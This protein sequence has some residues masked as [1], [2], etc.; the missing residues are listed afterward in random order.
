MSAWYPIDTAPKDGTIFDAWLGDAEAGEVSFYCSPDTRRSPDW[1]WSEGKFRPA[2]GLHIATFVVPT[3]WMP[4]P[5]AP[6][7]LVEAAPPICPM[8]CARV[9]GAGLATPGEICQGCRYL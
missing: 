9:I 5:P 3:H 6:G 1:H 4:R 7:T 8:C 2:C